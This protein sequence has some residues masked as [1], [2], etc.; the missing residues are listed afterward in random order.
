MK[1]FDRLLYL[2]KNAFNALIKPPIANYSKFTLAWNLIELMYFNSP[3]EHRKP[4]FFLV[5]LRVTLK[6]LQLPFL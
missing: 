5:R 3:R 6:S 2:V 1:D 4:W